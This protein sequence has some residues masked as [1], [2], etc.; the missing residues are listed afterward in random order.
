MDLELK[1]WLIDHY[2]DENEETLS[3]EAIIE[4]LTSENEIKEELE[5]RHRWYH[6]F[7]DTI[8]VGEKYF[9]LPR[10]DIQG[11]NSMEDLCLEITLEDITEV[12][13]VEVV[14][15]MYRPV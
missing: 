3:D 9:T 10:Y 6:H 14:T 5:C 2:K 11:D 7:T 12:K 8:Q 4:C 15:I 1:Q 13:P